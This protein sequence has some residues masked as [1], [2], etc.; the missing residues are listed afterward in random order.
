VNVLVRASVPDS[1]AV[2]GLVERVEA[3]LAT[4]PEYVKGTATGDIVLLNRAVGNVVGGQAQSLALAM[5]IIFAVL[6]VLFTSARAGLI[7]LFPNVLPTAVYFG[8]LGLMGVTLNPS[9]SLV[10]SIT[11]GIAMDDTLLYLTRFNSEARRL[12]DER[13]A[14][15]EALHGVIAPNTFTLLGL[16]LGFLALMTSDLRSQVEF[17]GLAAFTLAVAWLSDLTLTPALASRMRIVTLW[18]VM[19]L[20][21]GPAP[22]DTIPIFHGLSRRQAR[23]FALLSNLVEI[24]AGARLIREGDTGEEMYVILDGTLA[25]SVTR[26]GERRELAQMKRGD[27][28]G[29]VAMFAAKRSADVDALTGARLLRFDHEDLARITRRY[30]RIAAAVYRNLNAVQARRLLYHTE[31]IR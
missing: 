14:T 19:T 29:E 31:R 2:Q 9:T 12:A 10:A 21:L 5:L 26:E 25:A 15:V 24:P 7:A 27:V 8:A 17:G 28:V 11:L 18:D 13:K 6:A 4:L 3:R 30:P 23:I 20:D 16:C 22:Q 1:Q